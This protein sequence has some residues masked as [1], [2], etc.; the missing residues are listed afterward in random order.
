MPSL[1]GWLKDWTTTTTTKPGCHNTRLHG[2]QGWAHGIL[3]QTALLQAAASRGDIAHDGGLWRKA[4]AQ[5][6]RVAGRL[7]NLHMADMA[8]GHMTASPLSIP[9]LQLDI[10]HSLE[11]ICCGPLPQQ[12]RWMGGSGTEGH[13][14]SQL[15]VRTCECMND[16]ACSLPSA[17]TRLTDATD[18]TARHA[19]DKMRECRGM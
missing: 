10:A 2:T 19:G 7:Q 4:K 1:C 6:D 16:L 13:G 9:R 3:L 12:R 15:Y 14:S 17:Q 8:A 5:V 18:Q 11:G